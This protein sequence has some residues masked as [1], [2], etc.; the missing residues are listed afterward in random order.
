MINPGFIG[1]EWYKQCISHTELESCHVLSSTL[2]T[3]GANVVY[4][5]FQQAIISFPTKT[6]CLGCTSVSP[7]LPRSMH[8]HR[9]IWGSWK[10]F[11]LW[12]PCAIGAPVSS[13][14][15]GE[16]GKAPS[17]KAS[18]NSRRFIKRW[19]RHSTPQKWT[20]K[21]NWQ[22]S[23]KGSAPQP[24][25]TVCAQVIGRPESLMTDLLPPDSAADFAALPHWTTLSRRDGADQGARNGKGWGLRMEVQSFTAVV[26]TIFWDTVIILIYG[27]VM[28]CERLW[29]IWRHDCDETMGPK[30]CFFWCSC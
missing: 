21:Q 13:G 10:C 2:M 16:P 23:K 6:T 11:C 8:S 27:F 30:W 19:L 1:N 22:R 29:G 3:A 15:L 17:R 9:L 7:E 18:A 26:F 5:Q 14:P 24:A 20:P 4:L 12:W 28:F 25:G